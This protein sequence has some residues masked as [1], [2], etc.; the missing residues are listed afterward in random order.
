MGRGLLSGNTQGQFMEG[1]PRW[2]EAGQ[3]NLMLLLLFFHLLY[4][5]TY[6]PMYLFIWLCWVL[7]AAHGSLIFIVAQRV[8]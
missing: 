5:S 8:Y 1:K 3:Q 2:V 4:S 6:L 7:V